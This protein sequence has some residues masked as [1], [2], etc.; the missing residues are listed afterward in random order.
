MNHRGSC[1]LTIP[2][3]NSG[4]PYTALY[5]IP[6]ST[7]EYR[8][9]NLNSSEPSPL[10][11]HLLPLLNIIPPPPR[12]SYCLVMQEIFAVCLIALCHVPL[13]PM[14]QKG[15]VYVYICSCARTACGWSASARHK[16]AAHM[17]FRTAVLLAVRGLFLPTTVQSATV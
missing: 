11:P 4:P 5:I 2:L 7:N 6:Q 17:E 12:P 10:Y 3:H 1:E 15:R 8:V 13:H 16:Q 9:R 14:V